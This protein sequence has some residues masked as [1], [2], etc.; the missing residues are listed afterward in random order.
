MTQPYSRVYGAWLAV[1]RVLTGVIWLIH[2]VPKFLKSDAFMP[3]NGFFV[4]YLQQGVATVHGPYHDFL[5]NVVTPNAGIFAELVRLGEVCVGMS[6]V[7]GLFS[8]VGGFV[9]ILLALNYLAA[10]GGLGSVSTW[11][12]TEA[13]LILLSA[14]S[15]VLPT[16]RILGLDALFRRR[17]AQPAPIVAEFVPEPPLEGPTASR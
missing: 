8:R 13:C 2:G 16:G 6:L 1:L 4:N 10:R 3:P 7:L 17:P 14:T 15:L 12:T 11:G 5:A 9:G